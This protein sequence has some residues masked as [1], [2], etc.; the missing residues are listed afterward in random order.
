M[1]RV[2]AASTSSSMA[3]GRYSFINCLVS[4]SSNVASKQGVVSN[5]GKFALLRST[6]MF[7]SWVVALSFLGPMRMYVL[8]WYR[9]GGNSEGKTS[10]ISTS[11]SSNE[12]KSTFI[13]GSGRMFPSVRIDDMF[14]NSASVTFRPFLCPL[15]S[16]PINR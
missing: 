8:P 6:N 11:P 15:S 12:T 14:F 4:M 13:T 10:T 5:V 7:S 3:L 1:L 9:T 16:I 2:S